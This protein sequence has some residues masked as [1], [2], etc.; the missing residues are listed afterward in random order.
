MK[1][2]N[3]GKSKI[4]I[5]EYLDKADFHN[6]IISARGGRMLTPSYEFL[7]LHQKGMPANNF[8]TILISVNLYFKTSLI[9]GRELALF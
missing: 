1:I 8:N 4:L 9:C 7:Q 3:I 2:T 5:L 6:L